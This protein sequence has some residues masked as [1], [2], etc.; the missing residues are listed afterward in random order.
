MAYQ[1]PRG[2]NDLLPSESHRWAHLEDLWRAVTSRYGYREVRTPMFE[3]TDLFLR[4]SGETSDIV[5]KE[6]YSFKDKGDR[7]ISLKPEGTAPVMRMMVEHG[8][9][10]QGAPNRYAY[11]TPFF[12]YGRPGKGRFRQAHQFGLELIGSSSA[13]ADAEVIEV[14]YQFLLEAG[15]RDI[16]IVGNSI[17]R[18]E[19][20][21]RYRSVILEHMASY[22]ANQDAEARE[23]AAKNPLRMLDTKDPAMKAALEGLPPVLDFLEDDSKARLDLLQELLAEAGVP[24]RLDPSIVRGLDYYTETVFEI[25]SEPLGALSLC[26]GGRYDNLIAEIGGAPTPSV[27]FGIGIERLVWALESSGKSWPEPRLDAYVVGT[28]G[29]EAEA[30]KLARDLRA[31]GLAATLDLDMR[32][33]GQQLKQAVKLG[34]R[35][36]AIVGADEV[37]AGVVTLRDLASSEQ[38]AVPFGAV[39][40]AIRP[41]VP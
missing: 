37:A 14:A 10:P 24:F 28:P 19:C 8:L 20:R 33:L 30:R 32:K 7:D 31:A 6:M 23:K 41:C 1:A 29:T 25:L 5:S 15:V 11:A 16:Q 3:D 27:G 38:K 12:R 36:A 40:E 18:T 26:G 39:A 21:E 13:L 35:Y 4:T 22:L 34:A 2:T 17:G 9:L